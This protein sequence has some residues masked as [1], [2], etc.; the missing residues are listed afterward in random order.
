MAAEQVVRVCIVKQLTDISYEHLALVLLD[1][2]CYRNVCRIELGQVA[3]RPKE[4]PVSAGPTYTGLQATGALEQ[5]ASQALA[6]LQHRPCLAVLCGNSEVE[7]QAA[8]AGGIRRQEL[9]RLS[10]PGAKVAVADPGGRLTKGPLPVQPALR[11]PQRLPV[12]VG[13][14][15]EVRDHREALSV[16]PGAV[17]GHPD[18]DARQRLGDGLERDRARLAYAVHDGLTQVVTASVL[19]LE[20]LARRL[21]NEGVSVYTRSREIATLRAIGFGGFPVVVS[22]MLEALVL[23]I[24]GGLLGAVI[25]FIL[26]NNVAVSTLGSNF[27]QVVFRFAVTPE[28]V[29]QGLLIAVVIGMAGGFL[30][31]LR[32]ARQPVTT[33]LRAA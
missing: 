14:E 6:R 5:R 9:E 32:A 2:I 8:P 10:A 15:S 4:L 25:A 29:Q 19:E 16:Q 20:A 7:Q 12:D 30:P 1:S 23:A 28:L 22:I 26:F 18:E 13:G 11:D 3:R 21:E 24:A 31:A 33:A 17:V 27:T